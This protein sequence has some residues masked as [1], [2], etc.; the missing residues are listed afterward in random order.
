MRGSRGRKGHDVAAQL[1]R[2]DL[3]VVVRFAR[4]DPDRVGVHGRIIGPI[5]SDL[6][7][8]AARRRVGALPEGGGCAARVVGLDSGHKWSCVRL[9]D[10]DAPR[11]EEA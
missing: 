4:V 11:D 5:D 1:D 2:I 8:R 9:I 7:R 6:E 3:L 10:Q